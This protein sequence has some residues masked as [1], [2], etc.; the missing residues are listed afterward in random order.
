MTNVYLVVTD[1]HYNVSKEHRINYF[2]EVIGIVQQILDISEGYKQK[3]CNVHLLFLGDIIDA[4]LSKVEDAMRCQDLF[5]YIASQVDSVST[6]LGN[7]EE[8]NITDNP[9]WFLVSSIEDESIAGLHRPVQPKG[10]SNLISVPSKIVDGEVTFY[11]NH[12]GTEPKVPVNG[13]G[14]AIG[15][16]HQNV[17]S[18]NICK[19][20]GTFDDVEQASYVLPYNYCF[21]GHMHLAVGKYYLNESKTC[22]CEWLGTCVGTNVNEVKSLA[23]ELNIPAVIVS[24]GHFISVEDNYIQRSDPDRVIDFAKLTFTEEANKKLAEV[25][26]IPLRPMT[27]ESLF[28]RVRQSAEDLHMGFLVDLLAEGYD[29]TYY[30]YRKGLQEVADGATLSE[31]NSSGEDDLELEC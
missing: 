23:R 2:G 4:S 9:F 11:F 8:N 27:E 1:L 10:I 16:F 6:V 31:V 7:H 13:S 18:N 29:P 28:A 25:K 5:S 26:S 21:F 12:Y 20:W 30:E 17:G 22:V 3:G 24:D 19:M 15:L 14:V